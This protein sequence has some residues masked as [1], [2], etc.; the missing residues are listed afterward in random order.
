ME[1]I[2][3][4]LTVT[5]SRVSLHPG[6]LRRQPR[7]LMSLLLDI[8]L[9]ENDIAI[10]KVRS[11]ASLTCLERRVW[12]ACLPSPGEEE[13]EEEE[14]VTG[15]VSGWGRLG[16]HQSWSELLRAA[17]IPIVSPAEC[18]RNVSYQLTRTYFSPLVFSCSRRV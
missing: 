10:I 4:L 17:S 13:E 7:L 12:P 14:Y 11:P 2:S 9:A 8:N 3:D 1:K 6:F 18:K 16:D 5:T 15:L